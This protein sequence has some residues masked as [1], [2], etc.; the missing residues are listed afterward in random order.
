MQEIWLDLAADTCHHQLSSFLHPL[1]SKG[2]MTAN[3]NKI[4]AQTGTPHT[5]IPTG[6]R[7]TEERHR[8]RTIS[9]FNEQKPEKS[10]CIVIQHHILYEISYF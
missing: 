10:M 3:K 2:V 1:P 4:T 6:T 7:F 5:R 9:I 8:S